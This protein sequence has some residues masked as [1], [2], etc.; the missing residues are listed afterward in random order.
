MAYFQKVLAKNKQGY[1]WKCTE[2]GPRNPTTGK[3]T[4]ITR[5]A[6]TK[7]EAAEKVAIALKEIQ[8]NNGQTFD[9][10]ALLIDYLPKWLENYKRHTV[11]ENTF[12][13]H[14]RNVYKKIIP[15]IGHMKIAEL[16]PTIYQMFINKIAE[17]N[18]SRRTIE[19]IHTTMSNA[20]NKAVSL[21]IIPKNP[22]YGV[23]IPNKKINQIK[24]EEVLEVRGIDNYS[25]YMNY[26]QYE[27][28]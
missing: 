27:S 12:K 8:L 10:K 14:E 28:K 4:Q 22:C 15:L 21:Q 16:S 18:I 20:L 11:K 1:N 6:A 3:R 5:R 25:K 9:K 23:T 19:I 26:N 13:M 2:E 7:K 17:Q 24:K